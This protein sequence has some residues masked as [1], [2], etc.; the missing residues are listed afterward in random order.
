MRH[1][2]AASTEVCAFGNEAVNQQPR[3]DP[4]YDDVTGRKLLGTRA[5]DQENVARPDARKHAAAERFD[6]YTLPRSERLN[7][8]SKFFLIVFTGGRYDATKSVDWDSVFI[9][10]GRDAGH[11]IARSLHQ[12]IRAGNYI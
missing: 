12:L 2:I 10:N 8:Q 9:P 11:A 3:G 1:G 4:D 5:F 7:D 6:P